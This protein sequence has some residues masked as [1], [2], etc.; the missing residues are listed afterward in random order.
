M[1]GS[2]HTYRAWLIGSPDVE[3]YDVGGSITLDAGQSPHVSGSIEVAMPSDATL[4]A[5][6]PRLNARIRL[7]VTAT[8]ET[9]PQTRS[10]NLG[11]R[12]RPV[13]AGGARVELT[14]SSD[15]SLLLDWAP[16][17][18]DNT[19]FT[20]QSSLRSVTNYVLNKV[21]SGAAL[22]ASPSVDANVTTYADA[23]NVCANPSAYVD[24][25]GWALVGLASFVRQTGA[26]WAANSAQT[27]FRLNG[28]AGTSASYINYSPPTTG[29]AG[30]TIIVRARQMNGS[31]AM[32]GTSDPNALRIAVYASTNNGG[33]YV[34]L[35]DSGAGTTVANAQQ[36]HYVRVT[37]PW[38]VNLLGV[39]LVHGVQTANVMYWTDVRISEYTGDPTDR[40]YF[41]G[42]TTDTAS[43]NYEWSGTTGQ[44]TSTRTALV[45]RPTDSLLW[46]AGQSALDFLIPIV[47]ASGFRLVCDEARVWTLR[48]ENYT[49]SA[50]TLSVRTGVNLT[51]GSDTISRESDSTWFDAAVTV[52]EWTDANGLTQRVVD[53]YSLSGT[54]SRAVLFERDAAYPGPGFSQYAVRRAQGRGR[55]VEVS[56]V[57]DWTSQAEQLCSFVVPGAPTQTGKTDAVTF[58]LGAD[59][60]TASART[61]D[62]PAGAVDLLSGTVNSLAGTVNAL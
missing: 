17:A 31:S 8:L 13:D 59:E 52:Y 5:L 57:S 4:A 60:M 26:T 58:D 29:L 3:L 36:D 62:T 54:Y 47:Q 42:S 32:T 61:T 34:K 6:D 38:N 40:G 24:T 22:A 18:D 12:Q 10:F 25:S 11:L 28:S 14:V 56:Q 16:L 33:A 27:A 23:D 19:P 35:G 48:D 41:D 49:A 55:V 44:S 50:P 46:R 15:E 51:N 30:K 43:Y 45:D 7:D 53:S 9:G 1:T 2:T 21:I 20:Y 37:V 39:R